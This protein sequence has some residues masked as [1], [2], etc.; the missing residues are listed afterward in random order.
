[1][2]TTWS[3]SATLD[4]GQVAVAYTEM[5][6]V[7]PSTVGFNL[8]VDTPAIDLSFTWDGQAFTHSGDV[9][10]DVIGVE[11]L[12]MT[13]PGDDCCEVWVKYVSAT[14]ITTTATWTI[15]TGDGV[16]EH[17]SLTVA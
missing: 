9:P 16:L 13:L 1:M 11:M 5:D 15:T 7:T 12:N 8:T 3:G 10:D 6:I 2:T 4:P 17:P 14:T